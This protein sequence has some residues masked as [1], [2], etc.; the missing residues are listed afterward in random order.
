MKKS[1]LIKLGD[2]IQQLFKQ[3]RLDVKISRFSV[4]NAWEDI[5]GK[6]ISNHTTSISFDDHKNMFLYMD[7]SVVKN[8]AMFSKGDIVKKINDYCGY[9]LV[10]NLIIK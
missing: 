6:V 4:K 10:K 2:A 1:N 7:S 8:E 5:A 9:E 3:E